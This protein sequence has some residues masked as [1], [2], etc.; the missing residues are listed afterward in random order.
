MNIFKYVNNNTIKINHRTTV[1]TI[2]KLLSTATVVILSGLSSLNAMPLDLVDVPLFLQGSAPPA[3]ALSFDTSPKTQKAYIFYVEGLDSNQLPKNKK[4]IAAPRM[5]VL[6]YNPTVKYYPPLNEDGSEYPNSNFHGAW[7]DGFNQAK[8]IQN[9]G[10]QYQIII[11]YNQINGQTT[12]D[13]GTTPNTGAKPAYYWRYDGP[14]PPSEVDAKNDKNYTK[15][16]VPAAQQQNFANWYSYYKTRNMLIKASASRAFG[17]LDEGFKIAWQSFKNNQ[18]FE[19]PMLPL[20]G[21]HKSDFWGWLLNLKPTGNDAMIPAMQRAGDLF[22]TAQPY[23]QDGVGELLSC[24]QNFHVLLTNSFANGSGNITITNNDDTGTSLPDGNSYLPGGESIIYKE[25]SQSDSFADIAFDYWSRDLMPGLAN[26]VP[27][28]LSTLRN[29]NGVEEFLGVGQDPWDTSNSIGEAI[30]WNPKNNPASWQHMVN[31]VIGL[32]IQ[33]DLNFPEDYDSL[34]NGSIGWPDLGGNDTDQEVDDMWHAAI[35]SRGGF[36]SVR[37]PNDLTEAFLALIEQLLTRRTGS[38][39]SSTVSANIVT[40][41]TK[42]YRTGFDATDWSGTVTAQ[43]INLD[44]TV[45]ETLWDAACKLTG[46]PCGSLGGIQVAA[47]RDH[48]NR[49]IFSYDKEANETRTFKASS[50]T[51]NQINALNKSNLIIDG[52]ATLSQ[53]VDYLRGDRS[54]EERNG[55]FFRSRRVLLGDVIHSSARVIR[56]PGA[57]YVDTAFPPDSDIIENDDLYKDFKLAH[58]QRQNILLVGANDGMLHAFDAENGD[59]LWAFIPSQSLENMHLLADPLYGHQN[60]VDSTPTIRDIYTNGAWRT[61]AV[62]GLRLGG[63]GYYA[64]DI[65]NPT[66]PRVLWEFTDADDSDMGYSYGE[67]FIARLESN[68]WAAFLPNGYNNIIE[69]GHVGSGTSV[70]Y[71]VDIA[72][73]HVLKKFDT[74]KGDDSQTNGMAAAVV[75]D[76]PFDITGDAVF[77]GDFRGDVYRIDLTDSSYPMELMISSIEPYKTHITTPLRL[78]Q[79]Q[80]FSNLT[81]DIMVHIGTGKFIEATDKSSSNTVPQYV[82]G[83]F[84][85]GPGDTEYPVNIVE[86]S[87]IVEQRVLSEVDGRRIISSLPVAKGTNVGWRMQLPSSGERVIAKMAT[88]SSAHFLIYSSFL[89]KGENACSTGGASWIMVVDNRTGGQPSSGS[90]LKSGTADGVFVENQVFGVTPIGFAGG[91]GEILIIST[92]D[93]T[94]DGSSTSDNSISIPDFTWRRRSW[95]RMTQGAY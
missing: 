36:F 77:V 40:E 60:F 4:F 88:R 8:G 92:D 35:N 7:I 44:G 5:N 49:K 14:E 75:S 13:D 41:D 62:G 20:S 87:A 95:H 46:G 70:L 30:Y 33:G 61:V 72:N 22:E 45:G 24:Q 27:K 32:G 74:G 55:G 16:I 86:N 48:T 29:A 80:N 76:V 65:T 85:R 23:K 73:G 69:D 34:R 84:D 91:G 19:T 3:I 17:M 9:L 67:P 10:T 25:T 81:E 71:M 78:T 64:L 42:I 1:K 38:S 94:G 43:T 12:Y 53:L 28:Y 56:G 82:A 50:L 58:A 2:S 83:I 18:G 59:E 57:T 54:L 39:S 51:S 26:D 90:V 31:F 6:Y 93:N 15:I 79:Y 68:H 11:Q 52:T 47:T 21:T 63:Q 89:P 66:A 37:N